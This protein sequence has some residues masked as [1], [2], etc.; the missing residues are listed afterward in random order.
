MDIIVTQFKWVML[1][2]GLATLTMLQ[3]AIAPRAA[4]RTMFGDEPAEP[5]TLLLARNWG[6]L[7]AL[8]GAMLLWGA[9]HPEVRT[10]VLL[11]AGVSKLAFIGLV[12]SHPPYRRKA[13]VPL[14]VDGLLV[15]LFAAYLVAT[16]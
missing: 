13:I 14:M 16:L 12:L 4:F 5:L 11:V 3:A 10:L 6:V 7:V 8:T 9:F 15:A 2:G 1:A